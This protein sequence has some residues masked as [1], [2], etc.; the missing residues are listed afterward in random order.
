MK[1]RLAVLMLCAGLIL[2]PGC[3]LFR[4]GTAKQNAVQALKTTTGTAIV[5]MTLAGLAYDAGAFGPPRSDQA[6]QTWGKIAEQSLLLNRA[7]TAWTEAI[8]TNQNT[9]TYQFAVSQALAVLAAVLP[10][11]KK[12]AALTPASFD[13]DAFGPPVTAQIPSLETLE[14]FANPDSFRASYAIGGSR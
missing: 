12:Q 4:G 8:R 5:A 11:T 7:L 1:K 10:T 2:A 3:S 14:R 13:P 9:S 6:E